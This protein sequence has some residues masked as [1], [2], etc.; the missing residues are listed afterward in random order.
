MEHTYEIIART[1]RKL[2]TAVDAEGAC[3]LLR[4][5]ARA[6]LECCIWV[7]METRKR[8]ERLWISVRPPPDEIEQMLSKWIND[9]HGDIRYRARPELIALEPN[10]SPYLV[11]RKHLP[12]LLEQSSGF[13]ARALTPLPPSR[14]VANIGLP[15]ATGVPL[16]TSITPGDF[17]MQLEKLKNADIPQGEYLIYWLKRISP[18]QFPNF[19]ASIGAS[20]T[21]VATYMI[22][23]DLSELAI[24]AHA[25]IFANRGRCDWAN[26]YTDLAVKF[27]G[28]PYYISALRGSISTIMQRV[29]KAY[30]RACALLGLFKFTTSSLYA[31][32]IEIA[33]TRKILWEPIMDNESD[34]LEFG[35]FYE[36]FM[37]SLKSDTVVDAKNV[38]LE[39]EIYLRA[40]VDNIEKNPGA[41]AYA[42]NVLLHLIERLIRTRPETIRMAESAA[43]KFLLQ[44]ANDAVMP[45]RDGYYLHL[46]ILNIFLCLQDRTIQVKPAIVRIFDNTLI[47]GNCNPISQASINYRANMLVSTILYCTC[48]SELFWNMMNMLEFLMAQARLVR[49]EEFVFLLVVIVAQVSAND[50]EGC[51]YV[52]NWFARNAQE[53]SNYAEN[54][55]LRIRQGV[56]IPRIAALFLKTLNVPTPPDVAIDQT[57]TVVRRC[58][59]AGTYIDYISAVEICMTNC[60]KESLAINDVACI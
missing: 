25:H 47:G 44:L 38:K 19:V 2:Q 51:A 59:V 37:E 39:I 18:E 27:G 15:M 4:E 41:L 48:F 45:Y 21:R 16:P 42:I 5:T 40:E 14:L 43:F 10:Q 8:D 24:M 28:I 36:L 11:C 57:D 33:S 1:D 7:Y 23:R 22:A 35:G 54:V 9:S 46:N 30:G 32:S 56:T 55:C 13:L 50:I 34:L 6:N 3:A 31:T 29:E 60:M 58:L 49:V 53:M 12:K 52:K 26:A 17:K 20:I